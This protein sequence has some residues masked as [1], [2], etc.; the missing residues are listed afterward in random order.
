MAS[1]IYGIDINIFAPVSDHE[2]C[3]SLCN[4]T[5]HFLDWI[6]LKNSQK[7][8]VMC[9]DFTVEYKT[10]ERETFSWNVEVVP[11][12]VGDCWFLCVVFFLLWPRDVATLVLTSFS[13]RPSKS[14]CREDGRYYKGKAWGFWSD[15]IGLQ[16]MAMEEED[17][18]MEWH[19]GRN[20]GKSLLVSL[21]DTAGKLELIG[22]YWNRPPLVRTLHT[23]PCPRHTCKRNRS[24]LQCQKL[25]V[26]RG[27]ELAA[28]GRNIALRLT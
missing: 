21:G 23:T 12:F 8:F 3:N 28:V 4:R 18:E 17:R 6:C 13:F 7:V 11:R 22:K 9:C 10:F 25:W 16:K 14:P 5:N 19:K 2:L 15:Q 24:L 1:I 26:V 20:K 27:Y